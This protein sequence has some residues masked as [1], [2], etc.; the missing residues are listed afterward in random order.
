MIAE[1]NDGTQPVEP[2]QRCSQIVLEAW[3]K[4]KCLAQPSIESHFGWK[5]ITH[6]ESPDGVE[7]TFRDTNGEE[8]I[9]RSKYLVGADGGS[10]RVR[11]NAGI[12][13]L[14]APM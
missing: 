8:H 4:T 1:N 11:K 6:S 9:V 14:G 3:L 10:S 5:Y 2:G 13:M 12:K 7:S